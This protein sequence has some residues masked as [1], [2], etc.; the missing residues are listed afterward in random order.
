[1]SAMKCPMCRSNM[2]DLIDTRCTY[3]D[4]AVRRRRG[5]LSCGARFTTIERVRETAET[6]Q[7]RPAPPWGWGKVVA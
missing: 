1:M 3:G 6:R 5:C 7:H 4:T 2:T